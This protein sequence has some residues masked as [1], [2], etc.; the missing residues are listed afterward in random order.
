MSFWKKGLKPEPPRPAPPLQC[1]GHTACIGTNGIT[2]TQL[3]SSLKVQR[4]LLPKGD[5]GSFQSSFDN[6]Y[7]TWWTL[8][9]VP[10]P[11][12][13][14]RGDLDR[15]VFFFKKKNSKT[16]NTREML[17]ASSTSVSAMVTDSGLSKP[18]NAW[19]SQEVGDQR[20]AMIHSPAQNLCQLLTVQWRGAKGMCTLRSNISPSM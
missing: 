9:L 11:V 7:C 4:F 15:D 18:C 1:H 3:Q 8:K 17:P 10:Y 14:A 2:R 19:R 12:L 13:L 5:K 6:F 20:P 16:K